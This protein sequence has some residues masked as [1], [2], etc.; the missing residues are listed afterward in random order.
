MANLE[1][2]YLGG[3]NLTFL[4][5]YCRGAEQLQVLHLSENELTELPGSIFRMSIGVSQ[6]DGQ[7]S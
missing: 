5:S 4:S 6:C 2:L 3:N 7:S 1:E